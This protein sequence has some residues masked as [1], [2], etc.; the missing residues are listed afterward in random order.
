MYDC[1]RICSLAAP[2]DWGEILGKRRITIS[3]VTDTE[4]A[5]SNAHAPQTAVYRVE[6]KVRLH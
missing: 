2:N 4:I 6:R 3:E 5:V 1:V